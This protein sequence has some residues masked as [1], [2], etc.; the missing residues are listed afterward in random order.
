[1]YYFIR[2][3]GFF[4]DLRQTTLTD[5]PTCD[6]AS[7]AAY[8]SLSP[9]VSS[10]PPLD[11]RASTHRRTTES[12]AASAKSATGYTTGQLIRLSISGLLVVVL[13]ILIRRN[14]KGTVKTRRVEVVEKN[15][16]FR[17]ETEDVGT[18]LRQP[19]ECDCAREER[20]RQERAR[21]LYAQPPPPPYGSY[22]GHPPTPRHGHVYPDEQRWQPS[23]FYQ[24]ARQ[25]QGVNNHP[26]G[27]NNIQ[28]TPPI[29]Q[30]SYHIP[31]QYRPLIPPHAQQTLQQ[32]PHYAAPQFTPQ[33]TPR[34]PPHIQ[35][36]WYQVQQQQ[37]FAAQ[38]PGTAHNQPRRTKQTPQ[39]IPQMPPHIQQAYHQVQLQ[40]QYAAQFETPQ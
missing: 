11:P 18:V 8:E 29:P 36:A 30:Y 14:R 24:P 21:P 2:V 40:R 38:G 28:Q 26:Q 12:D 3:S 17:E 22:T 15:R 23:A 33:F 25:L 32:Q 37:R 7:G 39:Y 4:T 6:S 10:T 34:M 31:Y 35:E 1:M 20:L 16:Q 19:R 9:P 13:E 27:T 5:K